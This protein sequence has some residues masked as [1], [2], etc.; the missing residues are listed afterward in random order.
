MEA[1]R[2]SLMLAW[3]LGFKFF[4]LNF[5]STLVIQWLTK[6]G[7]YTPHFVSLI[8][9]CRNLIGRYW[10]VHFLKL[11]VNMVT[12]RLTKKKGDS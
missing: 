9:D 6:D 1:V 8:D 12:D 5:D 10:I 11:K 2:Y 7:Q 3:N 4:I